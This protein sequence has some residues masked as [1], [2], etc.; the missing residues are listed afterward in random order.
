MANEARASLAGEVGL[1][2]RGHADRGWSGHVGGRRR[3]IG[4]GLLAGDDCRRVGF[5][6]F[7][8]HAQGT[9]GVRD[10]EQGLLQ[11]GAQA[12]IRRDDVA[13]GGKSLVELVQGGA[14]AFGGGL[15]FVGEGLDLLVEADGE[16]VEVIE[17]GAQFFQRFLDFWVGQDAR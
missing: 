8:Q 15:D 12:R 1:G 13:H 11:L 5:Q 7:R 4:R 6:K 14:R 2:R 3:P 9:R 17:G 16:A 10:F